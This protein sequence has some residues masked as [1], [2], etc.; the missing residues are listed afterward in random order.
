MAMMAVRWDELTNKA[1]EAV[2][3]AHYLASRHGNPAVLPLH[4]L[5]WRV[6]W[7]SFSSMTSAPWYGSTCPNTWKSMPSPA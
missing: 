7:Q 6:P 5:D 1:K 4:L 2:Q 3:A